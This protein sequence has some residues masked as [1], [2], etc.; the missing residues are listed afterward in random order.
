M[1]HGLNKDERAVEQQRHDAGEDELRRREQRARRAGRVVGHDEDENGQRGEDGER[2]ERA[3]ELEAL[4][5]MADAAEQQAGADDAV[6]HDHHRGEGGVPREADGL[7]G[8]LEH[9]R[10]DQRLDHG[11]RDREHECAEWLAGAVRDDLVM[12]HGGE[13]HADEDEPD[14]HREGAADRQGDRSGQHGQSG[15]RRQPCQ[16]SSDRA[17][18][19]RRSHLPV[20]SR[21]TI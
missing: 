16:R 8:A 15:E 12:V 6:A 11:D 1:A 4:L 18:T 17:A 3:A 14:E 5:E 20:D 9:Q 21:R 10:R 13:H 2:R 19:L 7:G